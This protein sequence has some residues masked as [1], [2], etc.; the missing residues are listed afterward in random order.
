MGANG[1]SARALRQRSRTGQRLLLRWPLLRWE[2]PG[3][4]V[5]LE[6][7]LLGAQHL[8]RRR[9]S[10]RLRLHEEDLCRLP[11]AMRQP[12]RRLR[13]H[14]QLRGELPS[15]R[16]LHQ[17]QR[18]LQYRI[19]RLLR[20]RQAVWRRHRLLLLRHR[21]L[22]RG[23]RLYCLLRV[24][25]D[26]Q[27]RDRDLRPTVFQEPFRAPADHGSGPGRRAPRF[28]PPAVRRHGASCAS[29]LRRRTTATVTRAAT[30]EGG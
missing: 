14:A 11:G 24:R 17:R 9:D 23:G 10:R 28:A 25:D 4:G 27:L 18:G 15:V 6:R 20:E 19:R 16:V 29:S 21:H 12:R 7:R 22:L 8:R 3:R 26:V 2:L 30:R 1:L 5:L 13:R